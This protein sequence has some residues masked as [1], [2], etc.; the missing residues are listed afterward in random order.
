LRNKSDKDV[1]WTMA[2]NNVK[3]VFESENRAEKVT[4]VEQNSKKY[5]AM[6]CV[7]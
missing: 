6:G 2:K 7:I 1:P 4:S 5:T 3:Q